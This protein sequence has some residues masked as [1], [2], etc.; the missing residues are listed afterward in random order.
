MSGH[1]AFGDQRSKPPED[2]PR[3]HRSVCARVQAAYAA[4]A[5][6]KIVLSPNGIGTWPGSPSSRTVM[7]M[8]ACGV[9]AAPGPNEANTFL[10]DVDTTSGQ[11]GPA[12][13]DG[14]AHA[15]RRWTYLRHH[16]RGL[17]I[18]PLD[19]RVLDAEKPNPYVGIM[20]AVV[21]PRA[22]TLDRPD[23]RWK[24]GGLYKTVAPDRT[25]TPDWDQPIY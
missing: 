10:V 20:H 14:K 16:L 24:R 21:R 8:S 1:E 15:R 4:T 2:T 6:P 5:E 25:N 23:L 7:P 9:P 13:P 11:V 12:R 3:Q 22:L 19:D 17:Q 18:G